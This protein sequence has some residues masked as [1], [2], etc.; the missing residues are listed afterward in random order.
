LMQSMQFFRAGLISQFAGK[1]MPD[2]VSAHSW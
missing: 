1:Q 2:L